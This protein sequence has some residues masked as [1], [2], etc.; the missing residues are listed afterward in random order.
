[1]KTTRLSAIGVLALLSLLLLPA[2]GWAALFTLDNLTQ[3]SSTSFS[4]DLLLDSSISVESLDATM[5]FP[6]ALSVTAFTPASS[7]AANVF[8]DFTGQ[9]PPEV[10]QFLFVPA[11]GLT[12]GTL[13]TWTFSSDGSLS[14]EQIKQQLSA[15]VFP[16]RLEIDPNTGIPHNVFGSDPMIAALDVPEPDTLVL[17]LAG[18]ATVAWCTQRRAAATSRSAHQS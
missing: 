14:I 6:A 15:Q 4:V 5:L 11:K 3:E 9:R 17:L 8:P 2:R 16:G 12:K 10:T 7:V 1:M 18:L 13:L